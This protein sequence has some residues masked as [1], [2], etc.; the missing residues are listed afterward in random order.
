MTFKK[1]KAYTFKDKEFVKAVTPTT[2][3]EAGLQVYNSH[4]TQHKESGI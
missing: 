4:L 2:F 1:L 3:L